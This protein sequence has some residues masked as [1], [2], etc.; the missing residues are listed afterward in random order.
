[1]RSP[2]P[3]LI[4]KDFLIFLNDRRAVLMAVAVPIAIA[5]LF[6]YIFDSMG[7]SG[8]QGR[9]S[10]LLV[11]EDA[12]AVS[13]AI[14]AKLG[15]EE[16]LDVR[17]E[18]LLNAR[19][20]VRKGKAA[21]ALHIP[22][23]FG[24]L[25]AQALFRNGNKPEIVVH[26]DPTRGTE[27][28]MV[29]GIVTGAAMEA[30]SQAAMTDRG[31]IEQAL[32]DAE[33]DPDVPS[34]VRGPLMELLKGAR[35]LTA[36]TAARPGK[37]AARGFSM[38]F[39]MRDE[40]VTLRQGVAYN[41]YAH[42]FAGMAVQFLLFFG[43]D[44]GVGML[45]L[46]QRG[47]WSRLR[48]APLSRGTLLAGRAA[49]AAAISFVI[50][51]V[52]FGFARLVFQVKIENLAGFLVVCAAFSLLTAT[53][54]LMIAAIGNTPEAARG[55]AILV[56]LLA[57]MLGG[58]WVPSFIFPPLLQQVTQFIPT[59]WAVDGLDGVIWRGYSL[60]AALAPAA[61]MTLCAGL[62]GLLAVWRFRWNAE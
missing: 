42:S 12:S 51:C 40:A 50:L 52:M 36:V 39:T 49:S 60:G 11:D 17:P 37:P 14:G 34:D 55:I 61:W 1:M 6:G 57:V 22:R 45:Y 10:V 26:Q 15:A 54:G 3:A 47:L 62:F 30:V 46:R 13:R 19:E 23:G 9:I 21:V 2:L 28:G 29:K 59:R 20:T 32:K 38:P 58:A 8:Q 5:S 27:A 56:T 18:T 31:N 41:A 43:I 24:S 35:K 4:R 48:A 33:S 44:T 53:F 25:A 7:R 16:T